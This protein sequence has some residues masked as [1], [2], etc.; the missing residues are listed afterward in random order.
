VSLI[1]ESDALHARVR[2]FG[3]AEGEDSF[4]TLAL[5]I[6]RFQRRW[7]P[8]FARLCE[9]R[10]SALDSVESIPA[11]PAEAF[12]LARVAVH[13]PEL[14]AV[15]FV[16]S[17]TTGSARGVHPMR[18]TETYRELSVRFGAQALSAG[19]SS[20]AVVVAL[21]PAPGTLAQSSLGFMMRAFMQAF[22]GRALCVEP[23][24]AAFDADSPARWLLGAGG[25]D[26]AGLRRAALVAS[27]R[28]EPLLV[29]ATALS[30]VALLDALAGATLP[31]PRRT[32]VMQ[33]GG[34]KGQ[35]RQISA[36]ELR[37][38]LAGA[39]RIAP[40]AVIGE[41]GMT[42][43]SSQLYEGS[44]PGGTLRGEPG[45]YLAPPWLRVSAVD[46][47]SLAPVADGEIGLARFVDL[48]NVDSAVAIVTDDLVRR[49]AGG[50]ELCGRRRSAP[51]RGCSLAAE[52]LLGGGG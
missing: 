5:E 31:A 43:L 13:P 20:R 24:G 42:E 27:E 12:R 46:P 50:I 3:R 17:G 33:T 2:A 28:G 1:A 51:L 11:V 41:Y 14:D 36:Q 38:R 23:S 21:A 18:S 16:T 30:L 45:I 9:G 15:R 22:D 47:A 34:S 49:R 25:V 29:L 19:W 26:L 6:A 10:G 8:G 4:E 35:R 44:L 37:R 32:V 40:E 52:A 39:F 48:A 7:S